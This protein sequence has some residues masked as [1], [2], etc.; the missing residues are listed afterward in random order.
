MHFRRLIGKK[1]FLAPLNPDHAPKFTEWL[2][3]SEVIQFLGL[4]HRVY[5][6]LAERRFLEE[7]AAGTDPWFSIIEKDTDKLI[8]SCNL[9]KIDLINRTGEVGLMIGDKN[10]WNLGYGEEALSLLVD[11]AFNYMNLHNLMLETYSYNS[12]G[13]HCYEKVGFKEIGRRRQTRWIN[14]Q[15]FDTLVMDILSDEFES[16]YLRKLFDRTV[17]ESSEGS[18]LEIVTD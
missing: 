18:S 14:G 10:F 13:I 12:R 6:L 11:F 15:L 2:N 16:P 7:T 4:T 17:N 5:S 9:F 3:D 1:C 8:G